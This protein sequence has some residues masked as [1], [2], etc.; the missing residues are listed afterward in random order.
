[1]GYLYRRDLGFSFIDP[2]RSLRYGSGAYDFNVG[3]C[4][5]EHLTLIRNSVP[6]KMF[7]FIFISFLRR[8]S[9]AFIIIFN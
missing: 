3:R 8:R 2:G 4:S 7:I 5:Y 6:I 9:T 1:M